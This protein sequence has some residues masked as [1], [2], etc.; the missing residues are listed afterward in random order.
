MFSFLKNAH[1][2]PFLIKLGT[3]QTRIRVM[4]PGNESNIDLHF[5]PHFL[6]PSQDLSPICRQ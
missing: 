1:I 6:L 5:R 2:S 4:V 3:T